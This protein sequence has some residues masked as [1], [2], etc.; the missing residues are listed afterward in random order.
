MT[1]SEILNN[2][3]VIALNSE[4]ANAIYEQ[5]DREKVASET[6]IIY[7][8]ENVFIDTITVDGKELPIGLNIDMNVWVENIQFDE[9]CVEDW[10]TKLW[11]GGFE[12]EK[13]YQNDFNMIEEVIKAQTGMTIDELLKMRET[14][15]SII[16]DY[17]L[18]EEIGE[19][20]EETA[21]PDEI[22]FDDDYENGWKF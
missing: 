7:D 11:Y 13:G 16:N 6:N 14:Q 9:E 10:T 21:E 2:K 20:L 22:T 1:T 17:N 4:I 12:I 18:N 19:V 5:M 3:F 8:D 15:E